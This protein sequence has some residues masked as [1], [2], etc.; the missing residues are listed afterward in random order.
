MSYSL[1]LS[2]QFRKS[3]A[4]LSKI[5]QNAVDAKIGILAS[6][7]WYPS[8]RVKKIKGTSDVF[9]CSV[10]MDIRIAFVFEGGNIILLLNIG[11]HDKLLKSQGRNK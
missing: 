10:N 1:R 9:E 7:P 3:Y 2:D 8:L 6:D 4:K 11:H 5:E